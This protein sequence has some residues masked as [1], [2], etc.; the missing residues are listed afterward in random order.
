MRRI[1]EVVT[2]S[3]KQ[4]DLNDDSSTISLSLQNLIKVGQKEN[5]QPNAGIEDPPLAPNKDS[6]EDGLTKDRSEVSSISKQSS[7]STNLSSL[8]QDM[9]AAFTAFDR[10]L[11]RKWKK[12]VHIFE[13]GT[14]VVSG[15]VR[16]EGPDGG[17]TL[18][19][20]GSYHPQE[21]RLYSCEIVKVRHVRRRNR[22]R[23]S[24]G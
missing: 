19:V 12:P 16:I 22:N 15:L 1:Y 23:R 13:R 17:C 5:T 4:E 7:S 3:P 6:S 14:I 21:S 18:D 24:E 2:F 9:G 10:T 20:K 8:G 11:R